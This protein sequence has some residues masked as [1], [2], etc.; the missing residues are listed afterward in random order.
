MWLM[1]QH[2]EPDDFVVATGEAHSVREFCRIAFD[3]VSLDWGDYVRYD[4]KYDRPAEVDTLIGDASK[5][6]EVLGWRPKVRFADLV[7]IMVAAD[8]D[9][10]TDQV[11]GTA[12][13]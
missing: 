2:D 6:A 12:G 13:R 5:A 7:R 4:P 1:L 3:A 11:A 9:Q 10:V 8:L